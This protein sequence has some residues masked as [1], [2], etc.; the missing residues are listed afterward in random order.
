MRFVIA[1]QELNYLLSKSQNMIPIKPTVPILANLLIE[2]KNHCLTITA[3]DLSIGIKCTTEAK[4]LEEGV[5][6]LPAK[7]FGQLIRGL[8]A[9]NVEV[10]ATEEAAV[11]TADASRFKLNAVSG[12]TYPELPDLSRES[13]VSFKVRQALLK[14]ALFCT[15]FAVATK[16]D[17]QARMTLHGLSM[18]LENNTACFTGTDGKR[19]GRFTIPVELGE[20]VKGSFIL[21]SKTVEE[22]QKNL[23]DE[24][25]ESYATICLLDDRVAVVMDQTEIVAKLLTGD[26]P[27]LGEAVPMHADFVITLHREELMTLLRQLML[28]TPEKEDSARFE[29]TQGLLTLTANAKFVGDGKVE[30][31]VDYQGQPFAIAFNPGRLLEIVRHTKEEVISLGL[32]DPFNPG[33]ITE[34]PANSFF[35]QKEK[36][37]FILM[38]MR[39]YQEEPAAAVEEA[40]VEPVESAW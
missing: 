26:F 32:T 12:E 15:G 30:M 11:I 2:A 5:T 18:H 14:E 17:E 20:G 4:V 13:A 25:L 39:L 3:T 36:G 31:P 27:E 24:D 29:L 23:S 19:L 10:S 9:I 6:T 28:F 33:I 22:I 21:S 34:G 16:E 40:S 37:F 7:H 1:T 35:K 38:P 8:T